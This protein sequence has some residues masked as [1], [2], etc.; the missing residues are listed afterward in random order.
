MKRLN[1]KKAIFAFT[2]MLFMLG[3]IM[4]VPGCSFK[5]AGEYEA[6]AYIT[7]GTTITEEE[8][9]SNKEY[10]DSEYDCAGWFG[11][12]LKLKITGSF[13]QHQEG[14][15]YVQKGKWKVKGDEIILTVKGEE[16]FTIKIQDK[17]LTLICNSSESLLLE[18]D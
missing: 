18:K 16:Y 6:A 17:K 15:D 8:Y 14:S 7:N 2:T 3:F 11:L 4:L 1:I 9:E 13:E 10:Y 5:Y 12:T